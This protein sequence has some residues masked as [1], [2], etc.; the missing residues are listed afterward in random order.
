MLALTLSLDDPART[1]VASS[2]PRIAR[3]LTSIG[4]FGPGFGSV[5]PKWGGS[6]EI[7]QV[8]CRAGAVGGGTYVLG[9]GIKAR[10][11]T[12][13]ADENE[14]IQ[15][16]LGNLET[17]K[18]RSIVTAVDE[19]QAEHGLSG[20]VEDVACKTI[21]IIASPLSS[22]FE[23]TTEGSPSAAVSVVILPS[24]TISVNSEVQNHPVYIMAHSADTGECPQDQS[25]YRP[26]FLTPPLH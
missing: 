4:L 3:H 12:E 1:N 5:Y 10:L 2:L 14:N 16:L 17:I 21:S 19:E 9:S 7:A 23:S 24:S 22:L 25:M 15:V 20:D 13:A 6:A 8:A 26:L 11:E 18:T